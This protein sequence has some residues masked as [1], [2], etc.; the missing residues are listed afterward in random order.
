MSEVK[1]KDKKWLA[2]NITIDEKAK[3]VRASLP[4]KWMRRFVEKG[5]HAGEHA[6]GVYEV[7]DFILDRA[8][9]VLRKEGSDI[10]K[11]S[12]V[13]G[14]SYAWQYTLEE[15]EFVGE[16]L[17][18]VNHEI[19][20]HMEILKEEK[21]E[22][23][24]ETKIPEGVE[25]VKYTFVNEKDAELVE[26][27]FDAITTGKY[28]FR[29]AVNIGTMVRCVMYEKGEKVGT[30]VRV[31]VTDKD[32]AWHLQQLIDWCLRRQAKILAIRREGK[33]VEVAF[34]MEGIKPMAKEEK[35][36]LWFHFKKTDGWTLV[37]E[38]K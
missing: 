14:L 36:K 18:H 1:W 23:V 28:E 12:F 37:S 22:E 13:S 2:E 26:T 33:T 7:E 19:R 32:M 16:F 11:D 17:V 9:D 10:D 38:E 6:E 34:R 25:T 8:I 3:R 24:P 35:E 21:K 30:P 27:M 5:K 29:S 4:V 20:E 15:P 31:I